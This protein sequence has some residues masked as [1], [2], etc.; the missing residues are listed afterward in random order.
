[1]KTSRRT[2]SGFTLLEILVAMVVLSIGLLGLAGLMTTSMRDN[3]SASHRTQATWMA[4]DMIDRM[5]ANRVGA[6]AGSYTMPLGAAA[7]CTVAA[8]AGTLPAQ[9]IAAW[10][11]QLAC[12]LPAGTGSVA[13]NAATRAVTIVIQWNDSR[14][15]QGNAA[16]TFQVD[17]Q[18]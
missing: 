10:K 14:G 9:D 17:T 16:Q 5:R 3:L 7:A 1:M 4:Y 2:Q 12:V 18:L 6:I 8:P 15:T 11:S 13:V